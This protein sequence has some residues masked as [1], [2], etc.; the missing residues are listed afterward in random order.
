M[1]NRLLLGLTGAI[2]LGVAAFAA[3]QPASALERNYSFPAQN[4]C[5]SGDIAHHTFQTGPVGLHCSGGIWYVDGSN[6]QI[7][8]SAFSQDLWA[9][10]YDGTWAGPIFVQ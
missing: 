6:N 9:H 7:A 2:A 4:E 10:L 3:A 5:H 1:K 8:Y